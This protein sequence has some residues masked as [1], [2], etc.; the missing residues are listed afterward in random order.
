MYKGSKGGKKNWEYI[1]D[2][3]TEVLYSIIK[4]LF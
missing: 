1:V 2:T 4:F 3:G